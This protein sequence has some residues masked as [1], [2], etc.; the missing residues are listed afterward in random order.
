MILSANS[1]IRYPPVHLHA[2]KEL[3]ILF[4]CNDIVSHTF[5]IIKINTFFSFSNISVSDKHR[6]LDVVDIFAFAEDWIGEAE[7][8]ITGS[9]RATFLKK[10][11]Q[12]S[13]DVSL[14]NYLKLYNHICILNLFA[15][16][17]ILDNSIDPLV[18]T[19]ISVYSP[20][21]NTIFKIESD[22]S[23]RGIESISNWQRNSCTAV[24]FL[25]EN[26]SSWKTPSC[27]S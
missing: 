15:M 25:R 18:L 23:F 9:C 20:L 19:R 10:L 27:L 2:T 13:W 26:S 6:N 5:I 4:C 8:D 24:I 7:K 11:V 1:Q 3:V 22:N 17:I 21:L 16:L 14:N 12:M